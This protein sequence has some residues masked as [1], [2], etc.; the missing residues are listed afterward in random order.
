MAKTSKKKI[1]GPQPNSAPVRIL[2]STGTPSF[3]VNFADITHSPH[4]FAI[5]AARIP[6]KLTLRQIEEIKE[7][8]SLEVEAEVQ[9]II[10][11]TMLPG[12]IKALQS[13]RKLFETD[14][15]PINEPELLK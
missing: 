2:M 15:G 13:R 7:S 3:Y 1:A 12:L 5:S 14:M 9:L 11:P 10:P 4:E 8:G 6:T